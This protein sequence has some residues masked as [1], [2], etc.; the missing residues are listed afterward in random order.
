MLLL[1]E[2]LTVDTTGNKSVTCQGSYPSG[3]Q[4][5]KGSLP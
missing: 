3:G 5:E 1:F 2:N 4:I